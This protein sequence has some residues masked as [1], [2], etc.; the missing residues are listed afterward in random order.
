MNLTS[1][2]E[3]LGFN[4]LWHHKKGYEAHKKRLESVKGS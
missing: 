2:N 3:Y 4:H 1:R